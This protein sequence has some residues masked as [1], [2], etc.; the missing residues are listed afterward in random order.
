MC[1]FFFKKWHIL[2][3]PGIPL[4]K[5]RE[6]LVLMRARVSVMG[7]GIGSMESVIPEV[8]NVPSDVSQLSD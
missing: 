3:V 5:C 7:G 6:T 2:G 8:P 1:I 4:L